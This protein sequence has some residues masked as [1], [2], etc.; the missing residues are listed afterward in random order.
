MLMSFLSSF[1]LAKFEFEPDL[2]RELKKIFLAD[3]TPPPN[4]EK[5]VFLFFQS[6][7]P[8]LSKMNHHNTITTHHEH[9]F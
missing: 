1:L 3:T 8:D 4:F 2:Q 9:D 7:P 5:T 6:S